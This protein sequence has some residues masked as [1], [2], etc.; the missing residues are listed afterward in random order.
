MQ[1]TIKNINLLRHF[2][3]KNFDYLSVELLSIK[4]LASVKGG[5]NIPTPVI[6]TEGTNFTE[7]E[8]LHGL[9]NAAENILKSRSF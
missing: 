1:G 5:Y 8:K 3:M 2:A 6:I 7:S 9:E 4:E